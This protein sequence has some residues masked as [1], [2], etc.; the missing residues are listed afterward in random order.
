MSVEHGEHNKEACD[1][2]ITGNKYFDWI[3]TTAFYSSIHFID[4]KIFPYKHDGKW[5]RSTD[6][7]R[8]AF[9]N[10]KHRTREI[11]VNDAFPE[12]SVQFSFLLSTCGTARYVNY[13]ISPEK[14]K[15]AR[16]YLNFIIEECAKK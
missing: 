15:L 4:N 13:K 5:L 7:A 10:S 8:R 6:E 3:V 2:L 9:N 14:A 12:I 11:I 16:E 1:S